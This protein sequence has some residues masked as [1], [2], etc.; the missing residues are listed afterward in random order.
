[1]LFFWLC[2]LYVPVPGSRHTLFGSG[3]ASALPSG[4]QWLAKTAVVSAGGIGT[5]TDVRAGMGRF[6]VRVAGIVGM[7]GELPVASFST[8]LSADL[9]A[10]GLRRLR[11]QFWKEETQV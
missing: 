9:T 1:M 3:M 5:V 4:E 6:G 7:F 10:V 8:N 2:L 11:I